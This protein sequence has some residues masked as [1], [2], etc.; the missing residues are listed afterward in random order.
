[1]LDYDGTLTPI[2]RY[3]SMAHPSQSLLLILEELCKN[4]H[5]M[6]FV[7]SGRDRASLQGI[8]QL[9]HMNM[10]LHADCALGWHT[11]NLII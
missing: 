2:A 9:T 11:A 4:P 3:P 8:L 1:M 10:H 6:V 5:N 7:I